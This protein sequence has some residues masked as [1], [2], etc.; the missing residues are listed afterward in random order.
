[1][2]EYVINTE[3][4]IDHV[5][6]NPYLKGRRHHHLPTRRW[7]MA[8]TRS[9]PPLTRPPEYN[10]DLLKRQDPTQVAKLLPEGRRRSASPTSPSPT[11]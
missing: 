6:G 8:T 11:A 5:F 1:M 10:L 3:S 7:W 9:P 4:H 2:S